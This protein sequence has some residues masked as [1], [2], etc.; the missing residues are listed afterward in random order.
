M[1]AT[2]QDT[3]DVADLN[4]VMALMPEGA[5]FPCEISVVARDSAGRPTA[6]EITLTPEEIHNAA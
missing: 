2:P 6:I 5:T 3:D 1:M 4:A